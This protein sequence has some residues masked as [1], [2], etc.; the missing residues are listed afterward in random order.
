MRTLRFRDLHHHHKLN[1]ELGFKPRP[2][3]WAHFLPLFLINKHSYRCHKLLLGKQGLGANSSPWGQ[4]HHQNNQVPNQGA[5]NWTHVLLL[6]DRETQWASPSTEF[7]KS[8]DPI[9]FIWAYQGL[10]CIGLAEPT[11]LVLIKW[12]GDIK[13]KMLRW[14]WIFSALPE[15]F[16]QRF[17]SLHMTWDP[18]QALPRSW[19]FSIHTH[20]PSILAHSSVNP[21]PPH[22]PGCTT[23]EL[24]E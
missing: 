23:V 8:K 4:A 19:S 5:Q 15:N 21:S 16:P 14:C 13:K 10:H 22:C 1:T 3:C 11:L 24:Q 9:I 7:P 6:S 2:A 18:R 17:T 20:L 12:W